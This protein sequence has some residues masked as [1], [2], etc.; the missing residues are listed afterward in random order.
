M[1]SKYFLAR[2]YSLIKIVAD[3]NILDLDFYL[4]DI[5]ESS[6]YQ[7][8]YLDDININNKALKDCEILLVRS[9]IKVN[10]PLLENTNVKFIG[11]AT[12]GINHID[13]NYLDSHN[14]KWDYAP[15]CNSSAVTHYVLAVIAE[16]IE[17]NKLDYD[18]KIGIIGYGNIGKK[19]WYYLN[20]LGFNIFINDPLINDPNFVDIKTILK[21]DLVSLHVPFTE[22][23]KYKTHNLIDKNELALLNNKILIN[24]SRGGIVNEIALIKQD[25]VSYI[26][27]VWENEP[28]PSKSIINK[29]YIATPHIAGYSKEGKVNGSRMIANA[30]T[31][32]LETFKNKNPFLFKN[33]ADKKTSNSS[34]AKAIIEPIPLYLFKDTFN[35]NLISKEMKYAIRRKIDEKN[36]ANIFIK[37]RKNYPL[38]SDF[39]STSKMPIK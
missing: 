17:K 10:K 27:D 28:S 11:S 26:A 3:N 36:I 21:C 38:R 18:A 35:V 25:N 23:G 24:T 34:F 16:L 4:R 15:G 14:I 7:I 30:V 31:N 5:L 39:D 8:N 2:Q 29:A 32:Y 37:M 33:P 13:I 20:A 22:A 1:D 9:T 19:V 6:E 12:A